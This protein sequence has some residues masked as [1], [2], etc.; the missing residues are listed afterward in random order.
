M[1]LPVDHHL[2]HN[3]VILVLQYNRVN[4]GG[5]RPQINEPGCR[6]VHTDVIQPLNADPDGIEDLKIIRSGCR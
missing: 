1:Q 2:L 5:N 3:L 4:A 6:A